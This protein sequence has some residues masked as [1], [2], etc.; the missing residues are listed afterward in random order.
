M[1][2][3]IVIHSIVIIL[4]VVLIAYSFLIPLYKFAWE[5]LLK[6]VNDT[7]V[8]ALKWIYGFLIIVLG[9]AVTPLWK[10]KNWFKFVY[11]A[12]LAL[13]SYRMAVVIC[14]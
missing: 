9:I 14:I 10:S 11:I 6:E 5:P 7:G 4:S 1:K 12:L 8:L 2:K 3:R 13:V